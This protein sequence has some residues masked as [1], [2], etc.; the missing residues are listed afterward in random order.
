M[1]R[2]ILAALCFLM[3]GFVFITEVLGL[4]RFRYVLDRM[5]AAALGDTLGIFLVVLG[6]IILRGALLPSLKLL[7]IPVFLF[8]TSPVVTHLL[9]EAEVLEHGC[10]NCEYREEDRTC[11]TGE[12]D[13]A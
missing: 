1:I 6:V 7:L 5:H 3:A 10:R 8:L 2:L 12:G 4:F 11:P 9:A 13:D